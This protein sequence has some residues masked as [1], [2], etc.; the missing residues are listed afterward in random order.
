V[1]GEGEGGGEGGEGGGE[2]GAADGAVRGSYSTKIV[3]LVRALRRLPE[4]P[5]PPLHAARAPLYKPRRR[6]TNHAAALT[7]APPL[8]RG[9]RGAG[10]GD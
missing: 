5:A 9:A 2:E 3:A 6:F 4:V 7:R 1:Y 10:H 8:R